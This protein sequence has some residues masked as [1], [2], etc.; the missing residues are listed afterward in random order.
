MNRFIR[1]PLSIGSISLGD[2]LVSPFQS[3]DA[4]QDYLF[5]SKADVAPQSLTLDDKLIERGYYTVFSLRIF[6]KGYLRVQSRVR[7]NI[8]DLL[9]DIGGFND[10]LII[11]AS[12]LFSAYAS[13]AFHTDLFNGVPYDDNDN[14]DSKSHGKHGLTTTRKV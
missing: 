1:V 3:E 6:L 7:Y 2:N 13:F 14:F 10:G 9:G 5:F 11:L 8:W 12:I 4:E